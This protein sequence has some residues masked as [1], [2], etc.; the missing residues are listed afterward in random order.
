MAIKDRDTRDA[1]ETL[2][3]E[4]ENLEESNREKDEQ[5]TD[6]EVE[7]GRL[8]SRVEEL[9]LQVKDLEEALAEAY[10][11]EEAD[12]DGSGT[13]EADDQLQCGRSADV[14]DP[15]DDKATD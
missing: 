4:F 2:N 13:E 11:T 14:S 15:A 12:D 8:I 7:N 10:L 1:L 3:N 6:L 5:I 9:E